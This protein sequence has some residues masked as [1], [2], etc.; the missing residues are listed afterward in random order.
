MLSPSSPTILFTDNTFCPPPPLCPVSSSDL[1]SRLYPAVFPSFFF[2]HQDLCA[3]RSSQSVWRAVNCRIARARML[4][5]RIC[6]YVLVSFRITLRRRSHPLGA[7]VAGV[8]MDV[9]CVWIY[10]IPFPVSTQGF[11]QRKSRCLTFP[12]FFLCDLFSH[13]T[14][15]SVRFLSSITHYLKVQNVFPITASARHNALA[16]SLLFFFFF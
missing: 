1:L 13:H 9:E 15:T 14:M 4:L 3:H 16:P 2:P 10:F 7:A 8:C 11:K 6:C 12:S 5:L